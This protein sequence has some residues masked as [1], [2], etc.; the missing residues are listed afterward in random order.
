MVIIMKLERIFLLVFSF[1]FCLN[2]KSGDTDRINKINE[3]LAIIE[4][5]IF[6]N[7]TLNNHQVNVSDGQDDMKKY[8]EQRKKEDERFEKNF[9]RFTIGSILT[10]L[11][12]AGITIQY[13]KHCENAVNNERFKKLVGITTS[14]GLI[15]LA[16]LFGKIISYFSPHTTF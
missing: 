2:I 5:K 16:L 11:V 12:L 6:G 9:T 10:T 4:S 1:L 7:N 8:L 14:S 13:G 15:S 3:R